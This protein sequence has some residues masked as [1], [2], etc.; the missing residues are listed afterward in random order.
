[1]ENRGRELVMKNGSVNRGENF[2]AL[3]EQDLKAPKAVA[4]GITTT[5]V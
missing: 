5:K 3:N 2:D 1:M 4:N